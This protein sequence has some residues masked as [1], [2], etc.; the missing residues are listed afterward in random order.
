MPWPHEN[1][2]HR[3]RPTPAPIPEPGAAD[4]AHRQPGPHRLPAG[5]AGVPDRPGRP[6]GLPLAV[7]VLL[8]LIHLRTNLTTRALAILFATSQSAADRII[9]HLVPILA[10]ALRPEPAAHGAPWIIDGTLIPGHDQ[11][12]TAPAKNYRRS[13]NTQIIISSP[14]RAVAA[15]GD[16][17]PGNRHDVVMARHTIAH[18][19]TG[20]RVILGD[21]GYR[22][23]DT[24]TTP[25]R[26]NT[27]RIIHD[28]LY[29]KH[30]RIRARIEHVIARLKDWQILRQCRRRGQA[31]N[32]SL[33]IITGLWNLKTTAAQAV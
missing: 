8:V 30:R 19:L 9:H 27:G 13:I 7:R 33:H 18:L 10:T 32:Y 15:V 26:D 11:A 29:R 22:G 16:C 14:S 25:A 24:I 28:D 5:T 6:W 23:I 4:R 31:I 12:I 3:H 17:W 1:T 20:E 21:G 2:T